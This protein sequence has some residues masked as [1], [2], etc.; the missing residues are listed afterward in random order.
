VAPAAR[1][2]YRGA[3]GRREMMN[4]LPL[5]FKTLHVAE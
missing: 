5:C 2:A 4:V 1:E 3:V